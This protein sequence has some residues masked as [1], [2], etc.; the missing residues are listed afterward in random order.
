MDDVRLITLDPAHFH[1]A[2]LQKEMYFGVS[3]EVAVYAPLSLDLIEHLARVARFNLRPEAPTAWKLDV[4]TGPDFFERMLRERPGN[5]VVLS[6]RN[7]AKIDRSFQRCIENELHVLAD[8]PWI[9]NSSDLPKIQSTYWEACGE[10]RGLIA[11]DI[12]TERYEVTSIIQQRAGEYSGSI[13]ND[14][15]RGR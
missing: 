1:A 5:V 7:R 6:G 8:K 13:R 2:L 9:L 15:G 4:H 14:S 11:Y 12:M 3:P 10:E